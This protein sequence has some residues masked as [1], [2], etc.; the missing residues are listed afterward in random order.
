MAVPSDPVKDE[1]R[2][3]QRGL[4]TKPAAR[5]FRARCL[6]YPQIFCR[7]LPSVFLLFVTYLGTLI[8]AA[9]AGSFY[10]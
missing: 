2:A 9:Q 1:L 10:G 6:A 4:A 8:K 5:H 3:R 7:G